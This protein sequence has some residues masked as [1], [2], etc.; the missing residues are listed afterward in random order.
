[1]GEDYARRIQIANEIDQWET[2]QDSAEIIRCSRQRRL[3]VAVRSPRPPAS[4]VRR[5]AGYSIR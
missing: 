1:V 2:R 4:D 3:L 5:S